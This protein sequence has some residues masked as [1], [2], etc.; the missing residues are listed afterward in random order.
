VEVRDR[1]L[2]RH[3]GREVSA[4]RAGPPPSSA[5]SASLLAAWSTNDRTTSFLIEHMPPALWSAAVPGS[6]RRTVRML[7]GH[8]HNARCMWIKTLGRPHGIEPPASVDRRRVSRLQLIRA[9]RRSGRA[10]AQ[11][12]AFGLAHGGRI[13]PTSAYV[14]RNLPLDVGHVLSYFVAH[15]GHHRGQIVMLARQLGHRLPR[16]VTYGLWQWTTRSAEAADV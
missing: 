3:A 15:E 13:P 12:L 2:E 1:H 16:E 6:P 8:I 9:L 7:A 11:L 4:S 10:M 5:L 14:W